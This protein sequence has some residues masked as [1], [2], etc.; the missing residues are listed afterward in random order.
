MYAFLTLD[1]LDSILSQM[2]PIWILIRSSNTY[3]I[4]FSNLRSIFPRDIFLSSSPT[5]ILY[6]FLSSPYWVQALSIECWLKY[7]TTRWKNKYSK[8]TKIMLKRNSE[9][10]HHRGNRVITGH[11]HFNCFMFSAEVQTHWR[12]C[13]FIVVWNA[14]VFCFD[15]IKWL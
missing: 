11:K 14:R 12:W 6:A 10:F 15:Y 9:R 3:F 7:L 4:L 2:N 8:I 13:S 5:N 1:L